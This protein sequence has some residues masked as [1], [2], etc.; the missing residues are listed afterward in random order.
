MYNH[1]CTMMRTKLEKPT[2][3]DN[4]W[5]I[6]EAASANMGSFTLNFRPQNYNMQLPLIVDE[7]MEDGLWGAKKIPKPTMPQR[8]VQ[9]S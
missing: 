6:L 8:M 2:L 3:P 5:R 7:M 9:L 4:I 1:L